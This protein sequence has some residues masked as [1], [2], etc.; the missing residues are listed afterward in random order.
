MNW[1]LAIW[2]LEKLIIWQK[3]FQE[4]FFVNS[5]GAHHAFSQMQDYGINRYVKI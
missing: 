3:D 2:A 5:P 4:L 1:F